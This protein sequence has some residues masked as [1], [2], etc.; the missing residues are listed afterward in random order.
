MEEYEEKCLECNGEGFLYDSGLSGYNIFCPICN[1]N[2]KIN[3]IDKI[4][5]PIKL[6]IGYIVNL[7]SS[8][9]KKIDKGIW[10]RESKG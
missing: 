7:R 3:W 9:W 6:P 5:Y 8:T 2:K 10:L 1:G 4:K